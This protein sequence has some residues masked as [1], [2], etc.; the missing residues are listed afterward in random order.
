MA[1]RTIYPD[2]LATVCAK[3]AG[4]K[5][6]PSNGTEGELFYGA[7]CADCAREAAYRADPAL[8][9]PCPILSATMTFDVSNPLYPEAWQFGADGQPTCTAFTTE[10]ET[11]RCPDTMDMFGD[12]S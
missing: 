5:Y 11:G 2:D 10:A 1:D 6:R 7:W 9:E 12:P 4:Q 3:R 8:G